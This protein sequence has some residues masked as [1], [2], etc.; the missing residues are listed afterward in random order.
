MNNAIIDPNPLDQIFSMMGING[1]GYFE[2]YLIY[3]LKIFYNFIL[4][5][6]LYFILYYIYL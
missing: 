1:K 4:L 2:I 6:H 5:L 3:C